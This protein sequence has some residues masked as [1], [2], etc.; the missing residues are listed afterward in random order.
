M[1]SVDY[2]SMSSASSSLDDEQHYL[3]P[4]PKPGVKRSWLQSSSRGQHQQNQQQQHQHSAWFYDLDHPSGIDIHVSD[5]HRKEADAEL[6]LAS[7]AA[8]PAW[9]MHHRISNGES[10]SVHSPTPAEE[11]RL[12]AFMASVLGEHDEGAHYTAARAAADED[13]LFAMEW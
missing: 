12:H 6:N 5:G 13:M 7:D 3:H 11:D 1:S 4:G 10:A 9:E 8:R 2:G